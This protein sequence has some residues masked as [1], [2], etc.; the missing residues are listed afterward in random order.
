M[1]SQQALS[2]AYKK[3][4]SPA[5]S[6][7][8]LLTVFVPGTLLLALFILMYHSQVIV[9]ELIYVIV[10]V[11]L[12]APF[13]LGLAIN[14]LYTLLREVVRRVMV[15]KKKSIGFHIQ[16][17]RGI[18][19]QSLKGLDPVKMKRMRDKF[20]TVRVY[21]VFLETLEDDRMGK[22]IRSE[23]AF[24]TAGFES[25]L[26]LVIFFWL[27]WAVDLSLEFIGSS[28]QLES[29]LPYLGASI[30]STAIGSVF[31]LSTY[32]RFKR[33]DTVET[34]NL[35]LNLSHFKE[36][37]NVLVNAEKTYGFL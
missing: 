29:S 4:Y 2:D 27:L 6:L 33:L 35:S 20:P 34:A 13:F 3:S 14:A 5:T 37:A 32:I 11:L 26:L 9:A 21:R 10:I 31:C 8:I 22:F 23:S 15:K 30:I 18:Y 28:F 1:V 12:F 24:L 17:A 19:G 16:L 7:D 25:G 36:T